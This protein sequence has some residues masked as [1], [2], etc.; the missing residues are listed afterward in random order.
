MISWWRTIATFLN[1]CQMIVFDFHYT[2]ISR[3]LCI[4][5]LPGSFREWATLTFKEGSRS[6]HRLWEMREVRKREYQ[7]RKERKGTRVNWSSEKREKE[8]DNVR[9]KEKLTILC[10]WQHL[11]EPDYMKCHQLGEQSKLLGTVQWG[12]TRSVI[13]HSFSH[14]STFSILCFSFRA[15]RCR[16]INTTLLCSGV[17]HRR[18][19]G[20]EV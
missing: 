10:V 5:K 13:Q 1:V 12:D 8:Q 15:N 19:D 6:A 17:Q 2:L 4:V 18:G 7:R 20:G 11:Q 9:T 3:P 14:S 16:G